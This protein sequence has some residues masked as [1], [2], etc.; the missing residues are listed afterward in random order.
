MRGTLTAIQWFWTPAAPSRGGARTLEAGV[1]YCL[2]AIARAAPTAA[3]E[4][5]SDSPRATEAARGSLTASSGARLSDRVLPPSPRAATA[6]WVLVWRS[7]GGFAAD[8]SDDQRG[9]A[10]RPC[11]S[12]GTSTLAGASS[13][14][15]GASSP[16]WEVAA[17]DRARSGSRWSPRRGRRLRGELGVAVGSCSSRRP[18]ASFRPRTDDVCR[19]SAVGRASRLRVS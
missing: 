8:L 6:S 11:S 17:A 9:A 16:R 14:P 4:R 7:S 3:A 19:R 2:D 15:S 13:R 18:A 1:D 12:A 10:F 5:G